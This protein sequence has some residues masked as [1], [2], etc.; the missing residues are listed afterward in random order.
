MSTVSKSQNDSSISKNTDTNSKFF[1][2]PNLNYA[3][4]YYT[5]G[6]KAEYPRAINNLGALLVR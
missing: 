4:K 3:L 2:E 6:K 1:I 5:I